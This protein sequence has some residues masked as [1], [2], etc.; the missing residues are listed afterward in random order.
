[1][2]RPSNFYGQVPI[3]SGLDYEI[4]QNF[5]SRD[6]QSPQQEEVNPSNDIGPIEDPNH[7]LASRGK[8]TSDYYNNYS[9][10]EQYAK[11]MAKDFDVDVFKPD[12]TQEGGGH[13]FQL[14]QKLQANIMYASN[15]LRNEFSAEKERRKSIDEGKLLRKHGV[16]YGNTLAYSNDANFIPTQALPGV[17]EANKRGAEDTFD[18]QSSARMNKLVQEQSDKIDAL[19]QSGQLRPEEGQL[20]K[21]YLV[22]NAYKLAPSQL[23]DGS[24]HGKTAK[25]MIPL[26]ERVANLTRGVF[27]NPK[28]VVVRG[29]HFLASDALSGDNFGEEQLPKTDK[30]GNETL[31]KVPK[32]I[33][34]LLKDTEGNVFIEYQDPNIPLEAVSSNNPD[35][36]FRKLVE[37]NSGKYGASGALPQFYD[38]LRKKGYLREDR[39]VHPG[40][41]YGEGTVEKA[42]VTPSN[43]KL[44]VVLDFD[45]KRF[46]ELNSGKIEDIVAST[47]KG[48]Y[49]FGNDEDHGIHLKNW[50]KLGFP[51]RVDHLTYDEYLNLLDQVGYHQQFVEQFKGNKSIPKSSPPPYD[52]G[53]WK[54][55]KS[56]EKMTAPD[57][58]ILTK[59]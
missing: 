54:S 1:M 10:L 11:S 43:P 38:E 25:S 29:K 39:S 8:L 13:A 9:Q 50:K 23:D 30:M 27:E 3:Q 45:K 49:E 57:G 31:V 56:G 20:Q 36:V 21:S 4:P 32:N 5:I 41:V 34:R 47:P 42:R 7:P 59:K 55:L 2:R 35:E 28:D 12:Y 37:S 6:S 19:V 22:K 18:P 15:A 16:D 48:D 46:N 44:Q 51:K 24:G 53:K 14:A 52:P 26:Y 33:K 58:S 40:T 17:E